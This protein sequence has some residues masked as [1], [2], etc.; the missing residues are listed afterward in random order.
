MKATVPPGCSVIVDAATDNRN[1]TAAELRFLFSRHAGVLGETGSVAWIFEPRGILEV[2][3][4]GRDEEALDGEP[5]LV[6]GVV[7]VRYGDEPC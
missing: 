7:D 4:A 5:R 1:R 3:P 2:D 6:E